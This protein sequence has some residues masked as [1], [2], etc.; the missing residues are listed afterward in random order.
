MANT[1]IS[2]EDVS[3]AY[4][5]SKTW[6][7]KNISAAVGEGEFIAVMGENGS[8][9]TS[10]CRLINGLIP[11]SVKGKF[12]GKVIVDGINTLTSCVAE[13]SQ[14]AGMVFED[15]QMQIFTARVCDEAA[16]AL[17]NMMMPAAEI[18][19]KVSW[20]LKITGLD[21]YADYSPGT[22]S[23]GQKQRLAIACALAMSNRLLIM[24]EPSSQLDPAAAKGT[25][26]L[27]KDLCANKNLT[28]IMATGSCEEAAEFADKILL[29]KNG[30]P[31]AFDSPERIFSD[32]KL[33]ESCGVPG[34]QVSEFARTMNAMG[35][36]LPFFPMLEDEAVKAVSLWLGEKKQNAG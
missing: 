17:E 24:D 2:L 25:L 9:K 32:N 26:L 5:G 19:E 22:L 1:I 3:W 16:F 14:K 34:T 8:G 10:F 20:A 6:A 11:H 15:P 36:P 29:L 35:N 12:V 30:S 23:G 13:L 33:A 7:L 21:E 28:V 31:A 4:A 27:I 18:R